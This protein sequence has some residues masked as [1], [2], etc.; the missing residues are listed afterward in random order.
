MQN[1]KAIAWLRVMISII[2]IQEK[3]NG[4]WPNVVNWPFASKLGSHERHC[5]G[6]Y[7]VYLP[8]LLKAA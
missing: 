7:G 4:L 3:Y 6:R 1:K 2:G 8:A 5:V